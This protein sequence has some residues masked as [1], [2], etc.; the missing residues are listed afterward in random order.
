MCSSDLATP[1]EFVEP[2][3]AGT[4]VAVVTAAGA[5]GS[6]TAP[7]VAGALVD[8]TGSFLPAFGY[9]VLVGVLGLALTSLL[10]EP[11]GGGG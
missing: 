10:P 1:G 3:L 8:T 4:A 5:T 9:A 2:S 6:F 7:L 11:R